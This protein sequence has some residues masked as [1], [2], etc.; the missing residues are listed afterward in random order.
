MVRGKVQCLDVLAVAFGL[1]GVITSTG[2]TAAEDDFVGARLERL[3]TQA[4]PI[5]EVVAG[6]A[7]DDRSYVESAFPGGVRVIVPTERDDAQ[8]EIRM[9]LVTQEAPGTELMVQANAPGCGDFDEARLVDVDP[10]EAAGDDR[11]F[12]WTLDLPGRGDHLVEVFS[13]MTADYRL[14]V[15]VLGE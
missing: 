3:C 8:V 7:L 9:Y 5:C 15:D 1:A 12:S 11:I 4:I 2:C 14:T 13:D 6:C 10:F